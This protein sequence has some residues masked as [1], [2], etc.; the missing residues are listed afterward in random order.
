[1]RSSESC[2]SCQRVLSFHWHPFACLPGRTISQ[3]ESMH[4]RRICTDRQHNTLSSASSH[5]SHHRKAVTPRNPL[6]SAIAFLLPCS[7]HS[8]PR[9]VP[10]RERRIVIWSSAHSQLYPDRSAAHLLSP[11]HSLVLPSSLLCSHLHLSIHTAVLPAI[12]LPF[13]P[14]N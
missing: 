11:P 1:M 4:L 3:P 2:R 9:P 10:S 8:S 12:R 6:A 5:V 13:S 7:L 14:P